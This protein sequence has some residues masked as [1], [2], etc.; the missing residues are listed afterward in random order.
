MCLSTT[1]T[2]SCSRSPLSSSKEEK[3]EDALPRTKRV[4]FGSLVIDEFQVTLGDSIPSA[5]PP[6]ALE[7]KA[8]RSSTM[9]LIH[10]ESV[11]PERRKLCDL[12]LD[13]WERTRLLYKQGYDPDAIESAA[14]AADAV[15]LNRQESLKDNSQVKKSRTFRFLRPFSNSN[16]VRLTRQQESLKDNFQVKKS[17]TFC[18]PGSFLRMRVAPMAMTRSQFRGC[19]WHQ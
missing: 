19:V 7:R 3:V 2:R 12:K 4:R 18:F 17:R 5:G 16:A 8:I 9:C 15:R 13:L 11:R 6:I 1:S 14:L 10:Y